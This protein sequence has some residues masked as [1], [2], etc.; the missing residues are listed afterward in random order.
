MFGI[1]Y[2][3]LFITLIGFIMKSYKPNSQ[4]ILIEGHRG[5]GCE[6]EDVKEQ[7]SSAFKNAAEIRLDSVEL[8]VWLTKDNEVIVTHGDNYLG[9]QYVFDENGDKTV[10]CLPKLTYAEI[11]KYKCAKTNEHFLK[12]SEVLQILKP[13][14]T[15]LNCELKHSDYAILPRIIDIIQ[16]EKFP[17][18]RVMFSS[19]HHKFR[20]KILEEEKKRGME[21]TF[22]FAYLTHT[23][24]G[25]HGHPD[26]EVE[27]DF[28]WKGHDFVHADY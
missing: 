23:L 21:R 27:K 9:F 17:F 15:D 24:E 19:F 14:K 3:L 13:S 16:D 18:D 6:R 11:Q 28:I 2:N 20:R 26:L 22:R 12:L 1:I 8:D 10:I 25:M 7:T 4:H 5:F